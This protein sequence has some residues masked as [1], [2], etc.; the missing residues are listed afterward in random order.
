MPD[1]PRPPDDSLEQLQALQARA[2]Y[3]A[4]VGRG[5][6][7][8]GIDAA[9]ANRRSTHHIAA[10]WAN[11]RPLIQALGGKPYA[12]GRYI[13]NASVPRGSSVQMLGRGVR[14]GQMSR[15]RRVVVEEAIANQVFWFTYG[16]GGASFANSAI[17]DGQTSI[18]ILYQN[19]DGCGMMS[20]PD[21]YGL[22]VGVLDLQTAKTLSFTFEGSAQKI[23]EGVGLSYFF[24]MV[25]YRI[26]QP[27]TPPIN[28]IASYRAFVDPNFTNPLWF[29]YTALNNRMTQVAISNPT[30]VPSPLA[31][32]FQ[33][34]PLPYTDS[35]QPGIAGFYRPGIR[36]VTSNNRLVPRNA[37]EQPFYINDTENR[38]LMPDP[39]LP[40]PLETII[41]PSNPSQYK[42][43]APS[44]PDAPNASTFPLQLALTPGKYLIHFSSK[45][46]AN[47][48]TLT[49]R[50]SDYKIFPEP[51][52]F[53]N[54]VPVP[55]VPGFTLRQRGTN[56]LGVG[57]SWAT[58]EKF[59]T[60]TFGT[61]NAA[62]YFRMAV[63]G[64]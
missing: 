17:A 41:D 8:A 45:L 7:A 42:F 63:T 54:P 46:A 19:G 52:P 38:L 1:E 28:D 56:A 59:E 14:L 6:R 58:Y 40:V 18:D 43:H 34:R 4:E 64:L 37:N 61:F 49:N 36:A 24:E 33:V 15:R 11:G 62:N 53:S 10:G 60:V 32:L 5:D 39:C 47:V 35:S 12:L 48:L 9:E 22:A 27:G 21:Q 3:V 55:V 44:N 31:A 57:N 51:D 13:T 23:R 30:I 50:Y 26:D 20:N 25:A 2:R 29:N 16:Q